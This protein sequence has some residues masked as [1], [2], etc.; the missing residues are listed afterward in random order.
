M[1]G[2]ARCRAETPKVKV[3]GRAIRAFDTEPVIKQGQ[4]PEVGKSSVCWEDLNGHQCSY[5]TEVST[6]APVT[7]EAGSVSWAL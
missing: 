2:Q 3:A 7:C 1:G 5:R 6:S 4:D